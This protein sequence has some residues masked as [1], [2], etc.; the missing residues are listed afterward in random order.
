MKMAIIGQ[1][2][3]IPINGNWKYKI[4]SRILKRNVS[5]NVFNNLYKNK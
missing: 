3:M 2:N 5:Q 4:D 1:L